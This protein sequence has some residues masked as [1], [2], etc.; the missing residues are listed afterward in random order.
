MNGLF[1][2]GLGIS[3]HQSS[4]AQIC[5]PFRPKRLPWIFA[6]SHNL[7]HNRDNRSLFFWVRRVIDRADFRRERILTGFFGCGDCC[8]GRLGTS[9]HG[10]GSKCTCNHL[11]A[12]AM[13][14]FSHVDLPRIG[15]GQGRLR[16]GP[17]F[18]R[19]A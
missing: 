8:D 4:G 14:N 11:T 3:L 19:L 6:F 16:R 1:P 13:C 17:A 10:T 7:L 15:V 18:S 12:C 9:S 5:L 2:S